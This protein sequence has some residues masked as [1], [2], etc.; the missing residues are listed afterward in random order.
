MFKALVGAFLVDSGFKAVTAFLTWM[1][2]EIDFKESQLSNIYTASTNFLPL[3]N[4]LDINALENLLGYHFVHKGLLIQAFLHPSFRSQFGG[5]YQVGI[6]LLK[7]FVLNFSDI[8]FLG[9]FYLMFTL[10]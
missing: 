1:D 8:S 9:P 3:A 7:T 4:Q 2:I 6:L 10:L 5:C